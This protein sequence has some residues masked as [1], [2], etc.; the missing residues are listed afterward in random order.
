MDLKKYI[1]IILILIFIALLAA[2]YFLSWPQYKEFSAK[3][4]ELNNEDNE[5]KEKESYLSELKAL[6]LELE[7]YSEEL[8]RIN[9]A[10]PS[11]A[12]A[13]VLFNLIKGGSLRN[14]LDLG[15]IDIS[16]LYGSS[17]SSNVV[18]KIPFS[19]LVS[20][21]YESF[22]DFLLD[23]Y[24]S[25]RIVNVKS[26]EF[27]SSEQSSFLFDFELDLETQKYNP[28]AAVQELSQ[29]TKEEM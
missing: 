29:E 12:S 25:S 8:S 23:L 27:S 6:S 5:I 7:D 16:Q 10:L 21:G 2:G 19:V 28:G 26:L 9:S 4:K 22:K 14:S 20:G 17:E 24:L 11:E 13:A 3:N 1:P 18:T 15:A